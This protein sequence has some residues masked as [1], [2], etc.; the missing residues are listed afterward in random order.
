MDEI[1][2]RE[3][4]IFLC[5]CAIFVATVPLMIR[6]HH[7]EPIESTLDVPAAADPKASGDGV[8]LSKKRRAQARDARRTGGGK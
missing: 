7:T 1:F 4:I 2:L 5:V 6:G 8:R 3:L